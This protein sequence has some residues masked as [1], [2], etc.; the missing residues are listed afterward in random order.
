MAAIAWSDV[1]ALAPE[2][3][4]VS[5]LAQAMI[6]AYVN[7]VIDFSIFRGGEDGATVKLLRVT[8]AAH[9]GAMGLA[10]SGGWV[11]AIAAESEGE[12]S[13]QYAT[14]SPAGTD[15]LLDKTPYGQMYR[16]LINA[17]PARA[18]FVA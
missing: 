8:L 3:T 11:G 7:D 18:G 9:A 14:S 1:T 10:G 16:S 12:V 4:T 5:V 2:L 6:L 15:P 17:S 13:R